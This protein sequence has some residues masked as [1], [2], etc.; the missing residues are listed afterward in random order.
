MYISITYFI[1]PICLIL[2]KERINIL[3]KEYQNRF[4]RFLDEYYAAFNTLST[5][6]DDIAYIIFGDDSNE[7]TKFDYARL[8]NNWSQINRIYYSLQKIKADCIGIF[9]S[10][11]RFKKNNVISISNEEDEEEICVYTETLGYGFKSG[12]VLSRT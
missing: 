9:D 6:R 7:Y 2:L 11:P 1:I 5:L 12:C 10:K 4:E 8:E 3:M